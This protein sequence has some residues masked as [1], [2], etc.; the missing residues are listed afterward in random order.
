M[1][2]D[3]EQQYISA[4]KQA[5]AKIK[6]LSA[7]VQQDKSNEPTAIIGAGCRYPGEADDLDKFWNILE[8]GVDTTSELP[9]ERFDSNL[10]AE[11]LKKKI[12]YGK[13]A[14]CFIKDIEMFDPTFFKITPNEAAS[15]EPLHRML[16]E[17]S[18]RA[19]ENAGLTL[20]KITGA[21]AG[22]YVGIAGL[23]YARAHLASGNID[24]ITTYSMTGIVHSLSP[25]RLSYFYDFTG[26]AIPFDTAC[27]SSLVALHYAI[28][29]LRRNEINMALVGGVSALLG[30]E[31]FI[32]FAKLGATSSSGVC[33]TFDEDADGYVRGEGCGMIVI[34]RLSDALK[35]NDN[36]LAVIRGSAINNDGRSNGITAPNGRAQERVIKDAMKEANLSADDISYIET[37]GTGT[38]L[39]DP[40]EV[41][42]IARVYNKRDRNKPVLIGSVKPNIGHQESGAGLASLLKVI[43]AMQHKKVPPSINFRS[44]NKHIQWDLTPIKVV[45]KLTDWDNNGK[46]RIAGISSFGFS[47]TNAHVILEEPPEKEDSQTAFTDR[48]NH[49]IAVS[50][51]DRNALAD[52]VQNHAQSISKIDEDDFANYCYSANAGRTH[53]N[54]RKAFFGE[55]KSDLIGKMT[56]WT[57][58]GNYETPRKGKTAFL[59]TGH[60][61]QYKGMC[62]TLWETHPDFRNNLAL[63]DELFEPHLKLKVTD[64]LY[65]EDLDPGL[66]DEA[67]YVQAV[68]FTVG[69]SLAKL[70][71]DWGVKPDMAIG[72]STGEYIAACVCGVFSLEDAARIMS[73]RG[74][75]MQTLPE[76]GC[77]AAV[78]LGLDEV[79]RLIKPYYDD[80][81]IA[82]INAPDTI[83]ISGA[84]EPIEE[85]IAGL[86]RDEIKHKVLQ[87]FLSSHSPMTK[88]ILNDWRKE[89]NRH[90]MNDPKIPLITNVTGEFA[91]KDMLSKPDYW[92]EHFQKPVQFA[93]SI[94]F[95]AGNKATHFI[96]IGG[97][98][99]LSSMARRCVDG[100]NHQF[101][102]SLLRD[103]ENWKV[104]M[105]TLSILYKDGFNID[106]GAFD[107]PYPRKRV[108]AAYYP[109]Q[110]ERY[111]IKPFVGTPAAG[112]PAKTAEEQ[113]K[114]SLLQADEGGELKE[115]AP[116]A[117]PD[118]EEVQNTIKEYIN[119]VSGIKVDSI[120]PDA[121]LFYMGLDSLT[122]VELKNKIQSRLGVDLEIQDI[123]EKYNT[124]RTIAERLKKFIKP[125]AQPAAAQA[126]GGAQ[127][128]EIDLLKKSIE[129]MQPLAGVD[130]SISGVIR[131]QLQIMN[132]QLE[133]LSQT[134]RESSLAVAPQAAESKREIMPGSLP[135]SIEPRPVGNDKMNL[136]RGMIFADDD[137]T[138]EQRNFIREF[139]KEYNKK[140]KK[141][142]EYAQLSREHAAD[143]IANLGFR[144][145]LKDIIYPLVSKRS[146]GSRFTDAD[147][148]RYIDVAMGYGVHYFGHQPPFVMEAVRSQMEDGFE[149]GPQTDLLAE[150]AQ[151][152]KDLAGV[153]RVVF[154][155]TGTEAV[156]AAVRLA[157]AATGRNQL[158][159]FSGSFHGTFDGVL[160]FNEGEYTVPLSLGTPPNMVAD[161]KV[162][163]YGSDDSLDYIRKNAGYIAAVMVE[164]VQSRRP[165]FQP[166]QF[167]KDLRSITRQQSIALIF[168][169]MV[170]GFRIRPGGAQEYFD[171]EADIV[172]Y[173]KLIGGGMPVGAVAGKSEFMD[174][175]DGG[176]WR[177]GDDSAPDKPTMVYGGTFCK[178]P[179]T[180]AAVNAVLKHLKEK[181]SGLQNG[182]NRLA[183]DLA[184]RLNRFFE[185]ESVPVRLRHFSSM[186]RFESFGE[187]DLVRMP[188]EMDLIF[189]LMMHKG[190]YTWERRICFLSTAHDKNDIDRV[191]DAACESIADI[192]QGGFAF[193]QDVSSVPAAHKEGVKEK[194]IVP[195]SSVQQRLFVLSQLPGGEIGY[196]LTSALKL[197]G[198]LDRSRIDKIF[199]EEVRRHECL[200][201]EFKIL[202][203]QLVRIV[204]NDV[205]LG[206]DFTKIKPEDAE[207]YIRDF[208][209]PFDFEKPPLARAGLA[210][211]SAEEHILVMDVHH[212]A[213]DGFSLNI[214][215]QE[216]VKIFLGQELPP[217]EATYSEYIDEED[218]YV[219]S[220]QYRKDEAYW[221]ETL[222]DEI[223]IL[224][225][226]YDFPRPPVQEFKGVYNRSVLDESYVEGCERFAR[227]TQSTV[228]T[229]LFAAFKVLLHRLSNQSDLIVGI[230]VLG[231][232]SGKFFNVVGMFANTLPIRTAIER[233]DTFSSVLNKLKTNLG[234]SFGRQQY[235]LEK[236]IEKLDIERDL[237][238]NALFSVLFVYEKADDRL[239]ELPGLKLEEIDVD[240]QSS[241]FDLTFECIQVRGKMHLNIKYRTDLFKDETIDRWREHYLNILNDVFENREKPVSQI[242][243]FGDSG[244]KSEAAGGAR[245]VDE[246]Q[247]NCVNIFK[248]AMES[249]AESLA[250]CFK[251]TNLTFRELDIISDRIA[252]ALLERCAVEP[253]Q[254]V[255]LY[256]APSAHLLPSILGIMKSG[257]AFLPL[258]RSAPEKRI[259]A[260][261]EN[262]GLSC[263]VTDDKS[264]DEYNL[265]CKTYGVD[266]LLTKDRSHNKA[267]ENIS[268]SPSRTAYVIYTSGTTGTPKGVMISHAALANYL[269][270][271]KNRFEIGGKDGTLL[272]TPHSFDFSFTQLLAVTASGGILHICD[273]NDRRDPDKMIDYIVD[274][275][276]TVMKVLPSFLNLFL[277]SKN[278][279]KL[280]LAKS[281]RL[282]LSGGEA[283]KPQDIEE[284]HRLCPKTRIV[285]HYG[286]TEATIGSITHEINFDHFEKFKAE[287]LIGKPIDNMTVK[288]VNEDL[289]VQ[290]MG[291]PGEM[292]IGGSGL[293]DGYLNDEA[294]TK[295]S[296]IELTGN[297]ETKFY[298]TGDLG[299]LTPDGSIEFLGRIDKQIKWSGYR[300][301]PAEI[302][303]AIASYAGIENAVVIKRDDIF[304]MAELVAFYTGAEEIAPDDLRA[305][306]KPLLP[307]FALPA[308]FIQIDAVPL[309]KSGKLDYRELAEYPIYGAAD[310]QPV[311]DAELD[312]SDDETKLLTL[313]R[314]SLGNPNIKPDDNFF[315]IG[316]NSIKAILLMMKIRDLFKWN[317]NL[318]DIFKF[319]SVS[320]LARNI[321]SLEKVS[322]PPLEPL[323]HREYYDLSHAQKR[324]WLLANRPGGSQP[325]QDHIILEFDAVF[326]EDILHYTAA[327]IC[328]RHESLR[329]T[330]KVIDGKPR[331]IVHDSPLF[332]LRTITVEKGGELA[333][334]VRGAYRRMITEN[335]VFDLE[336]GPLVYF[337][338]IYSPAIKNKSFIIIHIHH[339]ITDGWSNN[340]LAKEFLTL[341]QDAQPD[342][343]PS[344]DIQYKD[345]AHWHNDLVESSYSDVHR[346]YWQEKLSGELP[347]LDLFGRELPQQIG[348]KGRLISRDISDELLKKIQDL[349]SKNRISLFGFFVASV[350]ALLTVHSSQKD[351]IVAAPVSGR[352]HPELENQVGFFLNML[353][354]RDAFTGDE[355]VTGVL[356]KVSKTITE[357]IEHEI[358]PF[359]AYIGD[360]NLVQSDKRLSLLDVIVNYIDFDYRQDFKVKGIKCKPYLEDT[361]TSRS[362]LNIMFFRTEKTYISIE[363]SEELFTTSQMQTLTDDLI[364]I[365]NLF[366]SKPDVGLDEI[367]QKLS[368]EDSEKDQ[369]KFLD[370]T[371][372]IDEDF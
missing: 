204:H 179:L 84:K 299:R 198:K 290:P 80:V 86:E 315:E 291:V 350:K 341:Y 241:L 21:R 85:I 216:F 312:L 220:E 88:P 308:R 151:L 124:V 92:I 244:S 162:L 167:L 251:D 224:D 215:M 192:R 324:I 306:L 95:A 23:E 74:E 70:W 243:L 267:L 141:S 173:G 271:F 253:G 122:I 117:P 326:D 116:P 229:T 118:A 213:V 255:G 237:S 286:P 202:D 200:R 359:D 367:K 353:I 278:A 292:L 43:L 163:T 365:M 186:L 266:E 147:G 8:N 58:A 52:A 34:K 351:L 57:P 261:V 362:P 268:I 12:S 72:H 29:S 136:T 49:I 233:D 310:K 328:M 60:G 311:D 76:N 193:R 197:T 332:D 282:L 9:F 301:E 276:I 280:S 2:L 102:P 182:V 55:N 284:F 227:E 221:L 170:T 120:D 93:K 279:G 320:L 321:D 357:A 327:Q 50:A 180:M 342:D 235:P 302:E 270:W 110:R 130:E 245:N 337:I 90:K 82:A 318:Q 94:Q 148:N 6:E 154:T 225:L 168:D 295:R 137:L 79:E 111:W 14:G 109:F 298:R 366:V 27:S 146:K 59:F 156:M 106:W 138:G 145:S 187:Y 139:A 196:H 199:R 333:E 361:R 256:M 371:M 184:E 188:I 172:T 288:I 250:V 144:K 165:G 360:L 349:T 65:S 191:V 128:V 45:D 335:T 123:Y 281:L 28:Q 178:H 77:M 246:S 343:L 24:A 307:V 305:Y 190:V 129:S 101:L 97:H 37:H 240:I 217:V 22:V 26:P 368:P 263:I 232:P 3:K 10:S 56:K 61:S 338:N 344:L 219:S 239:P 91:K 236:L 248:Q 252:S 46:P 17:T 159:I 4:L 33:R 319:P 53:F 69:Y 157:R 226:P 107:K 41:N 372:D 274:R 175:F 40:I 189:Y 142:K 304:P 273:E 13:Y 113:E 207:S 309:T 289:T 160:A 31:L 294:R 218:K 331:Q 96:E 81:S 119:Q 354:L 194:T 153:D 62:R 30:P 314:D 171:V 177:Y 287:P 75:L 209:K 63:C 228:F 346:K 105:E 317:V 19:I 195:M 322:L 206:V 347:S 211:I 158:V 135:A 87:I 48:T 1:T 247:L 364:K 44:P 262:S 25:A 249:N 316:G 356:Q 303:S 210:Q 149:M 185:D 212:I 254:P 181:G 230:P 369:Q 51:Q 155:N 259:Q 201:S 78:N 352:I 161:I 20:D 174:A 258:D 223:P 7:K 345:Y 99:T 36:I 42:A 339:I 104:L 103:E 66:L 355:T 18:W 127:P 125:K 265:Q 283:I 275:K 269:H 143:W 203:D 293:A 272:L 67:R 169:E 39:G 257:G 15:L 100:G 5:A 133:L 98:S 231:R 358:Y 89:L 114:I 370:S 47:G 277:Q 323:P 150:S 166:A 340:I 32:G 115:S 242:D 134:G 131:A 121:N 11:E 71:M 108:Q 285:N 363:Y 214:L 68:L 334:T 300:L 336:N 126:P 152:V 112:V 164:P 329:T 183:D 234:A 348:I 73:R 64:L 260:I 330:F 325:Y 296:F 238:R 297:P 132:K 208:A 38:K 264:I 222:K 205:S 35:D 16:L 83:T 176:F 140:T 54:K 313:W